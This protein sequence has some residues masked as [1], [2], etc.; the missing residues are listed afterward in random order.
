[1]KRNIF[2]EVKMK[3]TSMYTKQQ[4]KYATRITKLTEDRDGQT[5]C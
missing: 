5:K 3:Y 1:M 4:K 2:F